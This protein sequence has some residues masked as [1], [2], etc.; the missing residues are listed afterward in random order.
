ML[1]PRVL[2]MQVLPAAPNNGMTNAFG[3]ADKVGKK[4]SMAPERQFVVA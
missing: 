2:S 4:E 1:T 3:I